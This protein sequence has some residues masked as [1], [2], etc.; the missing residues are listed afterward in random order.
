[1][2]YKIVTHPHD[3]KKEKDW[4]IILDFINKNIKSYNL[5]KTLELGAGMGNISS[6]FA[7]QGVIAFAEDTNLEYL[8][9]IQ[10]RNSLISVLQHDINN[11]LPFSDNS[12]DL[13]S[14]IGTLHYGYIKNLP[15]IWNEMIRVSNRYI[16]VDFFSKYSIYRFLERIYNPLYNPRTYS[17]KEA[18]NLIKKFN[19]DVVS[20]TSTKSLS[21]IRQTFPFAGK[22]AYF[23]LEK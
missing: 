13:V 8:N 20:K 14:C 11:P 10:N 4:V 21:I 19:L 23:L 9:I 22:A 3:H 6:Y 7:S 12:F 15:L 18:F 17:K 2:K 5:K 16:L 1:M